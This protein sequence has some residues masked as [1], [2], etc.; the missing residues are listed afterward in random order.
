MFYFHPDPWG[1]MIQFD[2]IIFFKWVGSNHQ[3]DK[4]LEFPKPKQW[5]FK[6]ECH[7]RGCCFCHTFG[8]SSQKI[9]AAGRTLP[10][11]WGA[12]TTYS[13]ELNGMVVFLKKKTWEVFEKIT[14][15]HTWIFLWCVKVLPFYQK[16]LPF[17][18]DILHI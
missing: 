16:D 15:N 1:F 13:V 2:Y 11:C 8:S 3:L 6:M 4:D 9:L 14:M 7:E 10:S 12:G 18:A 5:N 17:K